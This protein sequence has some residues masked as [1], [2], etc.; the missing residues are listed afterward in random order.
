MLEYIWLEDNV[1]DRIVD[2]RADSIVNTIDRVSV[3][4]KIRDTIEIAI[5]FTFLYYLS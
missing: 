2:R 4:A 3:G 1:V 5:F